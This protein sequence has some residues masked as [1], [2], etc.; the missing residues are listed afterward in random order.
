MPLFHES[1]DSHASR[2]GLS[3][4]PYSLANT[5]REATAAPALLFRLSMQLVLAAMRA[6]FLEFEALRGC[7]FVFCLTVV[8]ILA[9]GALK[10]NNFTWHKH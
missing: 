10:L 2:S 6:E 1:I 8:P 5:S 7:S 9:F 3:S 4:F